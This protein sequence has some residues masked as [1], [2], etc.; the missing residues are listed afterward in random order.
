[1]GKV[2]NP[3]EHC[4]PQK[5]WWE[6]TACLLPGS[7]FQ[8][9]LVKLPEDLNKAFLD[10]LL[11]HGDIPCNQQAQHTINITVKTSTDYTYTYPLINDPH[12]HINGSSLQ[13]PQF[14]SAW[15]CQLAPPP[16]PVS[17]SLVRSSRTPD[18]PAAGQLLLTFLSLALWHSDISL[19][20]A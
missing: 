14:Q 6:Q 18:T 13:H 11:H 8:E 10:L 9:V 16:P 5:G 1:M 4:P 17:C 7:F 2:L 15:L 12:Q 3:E 19:H 20:A